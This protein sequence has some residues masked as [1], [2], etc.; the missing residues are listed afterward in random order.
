MKS[1]SSS[2]IIKVYTNEVELS[3][4][5]QYT[6]SPGGVAC[7]DTRFGFLVFDF[8]FRKKLRVIR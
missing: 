7:H 2:Y 6:H 8:I 4:P 3:L 5:G 1:C